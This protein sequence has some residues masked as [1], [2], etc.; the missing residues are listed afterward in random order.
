[1]VDEM[2]QHLV[3]LSLGSDNAEIGHERILA[4]MTGAYFSSGTIAEAVLEAK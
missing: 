1:M 2:T 3:D 4:A